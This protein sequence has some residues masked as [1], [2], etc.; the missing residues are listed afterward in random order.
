MTEKVASILNGSYNN[1]QFQEYKNEATKGLINGTVKDVVDNRSP[2]QSNNISM[3]ISIRRS[4]L[5]DKD[6]QIFAEG[7]KNN[8]F[9]ESLDLSWNEIG[10]IFTFKCSFEISS[11][12]FITAELLQKKC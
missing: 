8:V 3:S 1:P 2:M 12:S 10:K 6:I 5:V 9:L 4:Y 7:L 11:L